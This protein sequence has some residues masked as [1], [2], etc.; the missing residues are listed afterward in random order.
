MCCFF[1]SRP[2]FVHYDVHWVTKK[3]TT[4]T[5]TN[6]KAFF[7]TPNTIFLF[8]NWFLHLKAT[9]LPKCTSRMAY[10]WYITTRSKRIPYEWS[11]N[12]FVISQFA[13]RCSFR[14]AFLNTFY[15]FNEPIYFVNSF[16]HIRFKFF[17]LP[18]SSS[19]RLFTSPCFVLCIFKFHT[20]PFSNMHIFRSRRKKNAPRKNSVAFDWKWPRIYLKCKQKWKR[21]RL[22]RWIN[23]W[24]RVTSCKMTIDYYGTFDNKTCVRC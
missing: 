15:S 10:R 17:F 4:R 19:I 16:L 23:V 24:K 8:W 11:L 3:T 22:R 12:L 7:K 9:G 5:T 14:I 21:M 2:P 1:L 13:L 6:R 20:M 18:S